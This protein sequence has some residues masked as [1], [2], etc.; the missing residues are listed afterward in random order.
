MAWQ[1]RI[2]A[3]DPEAGYTQFYCTDPDTGEIT[4][5]SQYDLT[6]IVEDAKGMA[7]HYDER[8]PF[9]NKQTFHHVGVIPFYIWDFFKKQGVNLYTDKDALKK[10][11]NDPNFRVFRTRQC[12]V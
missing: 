5:E 7:V 8:T 10:Y 2:L 6:D 1:K 9:G 4:L 11:L 12:R 3:H